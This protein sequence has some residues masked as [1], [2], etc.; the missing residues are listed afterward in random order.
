MRIGPVKKRST[1]PIQAFG[2]AFE[3]A[4]KSLAADFLASDAFRHALTKGEQ[5]EIPVREFFRKN[6]PDTFELVPGEA[7]DLHENRTPQLDIMI[8]DKMKNF[9]FY[10]AQSELIPAEALLVAIEVKSLLTAAQ[11][12]STLR[13]ASQ[14]KS[15]RP[16]R[17]EV[18][19]PRR[20]GEH[21]DTRARYMYG[22]FAYDSD[23]RGD[24]WDKAEFARLSAVSEEISV[25]IDVVDR[26]YVANKGLLMPGEKRGMMDLPEQAAGLLYFYMHIYNFLMRENSRRAPAPYL[27]YAGRMT[28]GWRKLE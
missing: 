4:M 3:A 26:I 20:D 14:T 18:A 23:F 27:D 24:D 10:S 25:P 13:S 28:Q 11:L 19:G 7:I 17:D 22:L 15:L 21:A 2:M 16:F 5:R 9:P 12:Q 8:Y 1:Q 6:L